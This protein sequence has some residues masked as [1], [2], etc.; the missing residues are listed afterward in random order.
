MSDFLVQNTEYIRRDFNQKQ[1]V[2]TALDF[3]GRVNVPLATQPTHPVQYSQLEGIKTDVIAEL[4]KQLPNIQLEVIKTC[5][6]EFYSL[7]FQGTSLGNATLYGCL[8]LIPL[9]EDGTRLYCVAWTKYKGTN[10]NYPKNPDDY[11]VVWLSENY[12]VNSLLSNKR[13]IEDADS[14]TEADL[15]YFE[16]YGG[17]ENL[18][19]VKVNTFSYTSNYYDWNAPP[20]GFKTAREKVTLVSK[21]AQVSFSWLSNYGAKNVLTFPYD[22]PLFKKIV[23]LQIIPVGNVTSYSTNYLYGVPMLFYKKLWNDKYIDTSFVLPQIDRTHINNRGIYINFPFV[24]DERFNEVVYNSDLK[25]VA[26]NVSYP[27]GGTSPFKI[28]IKGFWREALKSF[29]FKQWTAA[30][31]MV[32]TAVDWWKD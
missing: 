24:K 19:P 7:A 16:Q 3:Q 4:Q 20:Y 11:A 28:C 29:E 22:N 10:D 6:L 30:T 5:R 2:T 1:D 26:A 17:V 25:D 13:V 14:L 8:N 21:A 27:T 31:S 23:A 18:L 12:G 9:L 15:E 32:N